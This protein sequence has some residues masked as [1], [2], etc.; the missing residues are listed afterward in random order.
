MKLQDFVDKAYLRKL[1]PEVLADTPNTWYLPYFNVATEEKFR[2]KAKSHEF[3]SND[4]LPKGPVFAPLLIMILIWPRKK[5]VAYF[6]DIR[7]MLNQC[8]Y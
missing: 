8:W 2:F 3:T 5:R 7:H 4:V 1:Y 6:A